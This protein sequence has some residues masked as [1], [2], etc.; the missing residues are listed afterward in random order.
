MLQGDVEQARRLRQ[1]MSLPEVVLWQALRARPGGFKFRKGHPAQRYTADFYC[2]EARLIV[3][4][5]GE[6]HGR[7]D[8]PQRDA[9][10]DAWF[11]ER[12]IIV[13]RVTADDVLRNLEGVVLGVTARCGGVSARPQRAAKQGGPSLDEESLA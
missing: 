5:D 1:A 6:A 4:V 2:H 13:L 7:G 10:R 11:E 3:E 9:R 8:R 12:G